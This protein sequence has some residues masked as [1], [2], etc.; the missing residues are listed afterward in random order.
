[1]AKQEIKKLNQEE[2]INEIA[3][4]ISGEEISRAGYKQAEILL[5]NGSASGF[6]FNDGPLLIF[7]L[8]YFRILI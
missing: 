6:L 3:S 8:F 2:R 1:M 7:N 5:N 4:L